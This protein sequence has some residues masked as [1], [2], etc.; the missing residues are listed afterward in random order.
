MRLSRNRIRARVK[1]DLSIV[2]SDEKISAHGGLE[3]FRRFL[4]AIDFP[5]RVRAAFRNTPLDG[6]YGAVR[7]VMLLIGL[8]VI[9][10]LRVTHLAFV[11]TDS[12]PAAL[13]GDSTSLLRT[14]R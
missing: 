10:G 12:D 2:F 14:A 9:G 6:D 5:S 1:N 8:L 13:R 7:M 4:V 11:G 3:L